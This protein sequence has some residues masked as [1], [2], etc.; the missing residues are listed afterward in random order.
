MGLFVVFGQRY[1]RAPVRVFGALSMQ[2]RVLVLLLVG[3]SVFSS[4]MAQAW[5][6]LG[7]EL[8]ALGLA[9][10]MAGGRGAG[11]G[12]TLR[13][14]LGRLRGGRRRFQVVEGGKKEDRRSRYLN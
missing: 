11:L 8:V 9:Y 6:R 3:L 1:D 12:S 4:L 2:A 10:L 13:G 14:L 7:G 5:E